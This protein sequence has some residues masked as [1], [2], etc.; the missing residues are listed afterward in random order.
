MLNFT[1]HVEAIRQNITLAFDE[2]KLADE[3]SPE[4][5]SN[6]STQRNNIKSTIMENLLK[7][8]KIALQFENQARLQDVD[9]EIL[10]IMESKNELN[11]RTFQNKIEELTQKHEDSQSEALR[12]KSENY[13]LKNEIE[14][15]KKQISSFSSSV[16]KSSIDS[17]QQRTLISTANESFSSNSFLSSRADSKLFKNLPQEKRKLANK[18][19]VRY[20][21]TK[22]ESMDS[23]QKIQK[24][25]NF[26]RNHKSQEEILPNRM[27]NDCY[28]QAKDSSLNLN[29]SEFSEA[30]YKK[31]RSRDE[32]KKPEVLQNPTSESLAKYFNIKKES[33]GRNILIQPRVKHQ[34]GTAD[35]LA[36]RIRTKSGNGILNSTYSPSKA[37]KSTK[38]L[39]VTKTKSPLHCAKDQHKFYKRKTSFQTL[40]KKP[41]KPSGRNTYGCLASKQKFVPAQAQSSSTS[42]SLL[43]KPKKVLCSDIDTSHPSLCFPTEGPLTSRQSKT[44]ATTGVSPVG[45]SL[46]GFQSGLLGLQERRN[47]RKIKKQQMSEERC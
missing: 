41:I 33:K 45:L 12:L 22:A 26:L 16:Y 20:T 5:C 47:Q 3:R 44:P 39:K 9:Q 2:L 29:S 25:H 24:K 23:P 40:K 30:L 28:S 10:S 42:I 14:R 31:R 17:T 7:F 37:V 36:E 1:K 11:A 8:Q 38:I 18:S 15:L 13:K 4:I 19:E 35:V 32:R 43:S 27:K 34:K 46:G 6:F 21:H